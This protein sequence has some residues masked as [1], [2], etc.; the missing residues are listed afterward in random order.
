MAQRSTINRLTPYMFVA[1]AGLVMLL[2]LFYPI[3]YMIWGSFRDWDPSQSISET[4]F[5]GLANYAR[6][7]VDPAFHASFWV[8][9]V[10]AFTV[11][12]VEMVLGVGLALLLD[13][14]RSEERRV[15]KECRSRWSPYH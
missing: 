9:M 10:F 6:L 8:T 11:V 4:E 13:R 3:S 1:P 14:N 7:L 15:G 5:V 12:A 2:A